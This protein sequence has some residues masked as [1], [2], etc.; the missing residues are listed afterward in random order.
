MKVQDLVL[1]VLKGHYGPFVLSGGLA[2]SKYYLHHRNSQDIDLMACKN[3]FYAEESSKICRRLQDHFFEGISVTDRYSDFTRLEVTVGADLKIELINDV[4]GRWLEPV[5]CDGIPVD[6]LAD[7]LVSKVNCLLQRDSP[8]DLIDFMAI[9]SACLINW[10][11]VLLFARRKAMLAQ[12]FVLRKIIRRVTAFR[13]MISGV[14]L[15]DIFRIP[16]L[17]QM[18]RM[19]YRVVFVGIIPANQDSVAGKN[20]CATLE[21][22][23][24]RLEAVLASLETLAFRNDAVALQLQD[25]IPSEIFLRWGG[26][27]IRV[28]RIAIP[29][30]GLLS[31][32]LDNY[33][34]YESTVASTGRRV[35]LCEAIPRLKP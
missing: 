28:H 11:D 30:S 26:A 31:G 2:L 29:S 1:E 8:N 25:L 5:L 23:C 6:S 22:F 13:R 12:A 32:R 33:D 17:P 19:D 21:G 20:E 34:Q 27:L 24:E 7:I 3:P 15:L 10:E 35:P 18:W 9:R 14:E 4:G 16:G